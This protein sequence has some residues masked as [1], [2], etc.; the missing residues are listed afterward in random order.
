MVSIKWLSRI[1]ETI[2]AGI[3]LLL[4]ISLGQCVPDNDEDDAILPARCAIEPTCCGLCFGSAPPTSLHPEF[5]GT[6]EFNDTIS[7]CEQTTITY[8][9]DETVVT[10]WQLEETKDS[11]ATNNEQNLQLE[12]KIESGEYCEKAWLNPEAPW[13]CYS[14]SIDA[15][16]LVIDGKTYTKQ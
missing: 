3:C 16:D 6:W 8:I 12:W 11:C 1:A 13:N 15:T 2:S 9:F 10:N 14:Y 4:L 7:A 5:I